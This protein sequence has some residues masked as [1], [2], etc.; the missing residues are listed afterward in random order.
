MDT[1][2]YRTAWEHYGQEWARL[3]LRL[4][5]LMKR[6]EG[7]D[8][9][10]D[11][12]MLPFKGLVL[13]EEEMHRSLYDD[14]GR[15]ED[16][17]LA[18][19]RRQLADMDAE[20]ARK[21]RAALEQ[22]LF[23]PVLYLSQVFGL[24]EFEEQTVLMA[25]ALEADRKYEKLYA[26]VQDDATCK[27]LTPE[28]AIRLYGLSGSE[29][30]G[31]LKAFMNG[32][33]LQEWFLRSEG[34][35]PESVSGSLL[36]RP[37]R[38]DERMTAFLLGIGYT[39]PSLRRYSRLYEAG[40]DLPD[41]ETG[42]ELQSKLRAYLEGYKAS[43]PVP[44]F[45][46]W[47]PPGSGKKLQTRHA[48]AYWDK[49]LLVADI[50][51]SLR[52]ERTFS[53]LIAKVFR[54]GMLYGAIVAFERFHLLLGEDEGLGRKRRELLSRIQW[55]QGPI[56]LLSEQAWHPE[57]L[58][59]GKLFLEVEVGVPDAT[60][61][62]RL[63]E[64]WSTERGLGQ[65]ADWGAV[66][67]KFRFSPGQIAGSLDYTVQLLRWNGRSHGNVDESAVLHR[68]CYAQ[69]QHNLKKKAVRIEPKYDWD[70]VILPPSKRNN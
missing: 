24:N 34:G 56:F 68:A 22:D 49:P 35:T 26:Y 11:P 48:A 20:L 13:T 8:T 32:S 38:L 45:C 70:Q 51:G 23:L 40:R 60:Q 54:E 36:S 58:Q 9:H 12:S 5:I 50:E 39:D 25:L 59:G 30:P 66:A 7:P 64:S 16:S 6:M 37:L 2:V 55:M 19:L 1:P 10:T 46:L 42:Q 47:G 27:Y 18:E 69:V 29:G 52:D 31:L 28:L 33:R 44:V 53:E 17:E 65:A 57:P 63:W 43:D 4:A 41:L 15:E 3:D 62:K 61:R 67:G 14:D 21:R